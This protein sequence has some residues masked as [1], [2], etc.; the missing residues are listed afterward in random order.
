MNALITG[1][2]HGLGKA[3]ALEFAQNNIEVWGAS[4]DTSQF[5]NKLENIH[6][7]DADLSTKQGCELFVKSVKENC[8]CPDILVNNLGVFEANNLFDIDE[9][10]LES[11]FLKNFYSAFRITQPFINEIK[12]RKQ[13]TYI[14]NICSIA[15]INP[16]NDCFSYC[17]SK[18]LLRSYST[19]LRLGLNE[20]NVQVSTILPSAINTSTWDN[21]ENASL[22]KMI[23]PEEIAETILFNI[24]NLRSGIQEEIIIE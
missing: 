10:Q 22:N 8:S 23:Q 14:F 5:K 1:V 19:Q 2:S 21:D 13:K 9:E 15:C 17:L 11:A 12:A 16:R 7:C 18:D 4:R 6:L 24:R 20:F 3:I